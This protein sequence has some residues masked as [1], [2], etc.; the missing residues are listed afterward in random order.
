MIHL[1]TQEDID[2]FQKAQ[3]ERILAS[4]NH[5]EDPKK[6]KLVTKDEFEKSHPAD[7]FEIYSLSALHKF[8]QDLLKADGVS[9]P[10]A[11]FRQATSDLKAWM[12]TDMGKKNLMFTKKKA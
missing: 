11:V 5:E 8:R 2:G 1:S 9:E 10:E 7:Q 6:V 3:K 12:V 4:F